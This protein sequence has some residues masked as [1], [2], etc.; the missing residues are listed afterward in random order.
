MVAVGAGEYIPIVYQRGQ[1][2]HA[3][4]TGNTLGPKHFAGFDVQA[5]QMGASLDEQL[6]HA[7]QFRDCR[8]GKGTSHHT[9]PV[10]KR[11]PNHGASIFVEFVESTS[12]LYV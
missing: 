12:G 4:E 11:F 7:I 9:T 5:V 2:V 8:R 6:P 10:G 3:A 1:N